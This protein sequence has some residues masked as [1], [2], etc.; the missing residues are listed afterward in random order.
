MH[1]RDRCFVTYFLIDI[2]FLADAND[3]LNF[4]QVF[5]IRRL[6]DDV[7]EHIAIITAFYVIVNCWIHIKL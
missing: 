6:W 4:F 2:R 3:N 5:K 1:F 7:I